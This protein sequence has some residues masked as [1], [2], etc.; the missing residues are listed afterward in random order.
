MT[1]AFHVGIFG[2]TAA[3]SPS[4]GVV[5]AYPVVARVLI[6]D[7]DLATTPDP[8]GLEGL[9]VGLVAFARLRRVHPV[10]GFSSE[11]DVLS[12]RLAPI[13]PPSPR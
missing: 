9:I 1:S 6:A 2:A 11:K 13:I 12:G 8:R 3:A 10:D 4:T 5:T 7:H